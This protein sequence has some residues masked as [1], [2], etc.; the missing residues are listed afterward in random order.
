MMV[1]HQKKAFAKA[2]VTNY[3][4]VK[5]F[6]QYVKITKMAK[7]EDKSDDDLNITCFPT[8]AI[9]NVGVGA[10]LPLPVKLDGNLTHIKFLV[11][12]KNT[13]GIPLNA[14]WYLIDSGAGATIGF[15]NEF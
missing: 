15:L 2:L 14:L 1:D 7:G 5:E 8:I 10:S 3:E 12:G 11:G 4:P 9:L 6:K 13:K